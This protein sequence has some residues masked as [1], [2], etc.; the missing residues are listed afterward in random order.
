MSSENPQLVASVVS[1]LANALQVAIPTA[2]RLR[3][4]LDE[5][6]RD[7]N[8]LEAALDRAMQAIRQ[9]QPPRQDRP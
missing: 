2:A 8:T 6:A 7:A 4:R 1:H 9:L 3:Q 5:Q